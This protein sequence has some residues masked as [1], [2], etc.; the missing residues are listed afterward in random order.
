MKESMSLRVKVKL[1]KNVTLAESILGY[2]NL[3]YYSL[4]D[5]EVLGIF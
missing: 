5:K 1:A 4:Y 2:T 3:Y